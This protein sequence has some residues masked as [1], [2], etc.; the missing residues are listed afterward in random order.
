MNVLQDFNYV[1]ISVSIKFSY[2]AL[3]TWF[4]LQIEEVCWHEDPHSREAS[5]TCSNKKIIIQ[6]TLH[7]HKYSHSYPILTA[8]IL[9]RSCRLHPFLHSD[10]HTYLIKTTENCA[11]HTFY[12]PFSPINTSLHKLQITIPWR[13]GGSYNS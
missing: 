7:T 12:P 11:S 1:S 10:K 13:L 6:V 9:V 5:S 2:L 8:S 4:I 3:F